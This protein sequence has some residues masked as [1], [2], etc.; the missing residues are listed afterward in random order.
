MREPGQGFVPFSPQA[1]I[2]FDVEIF[3]RESGELISRPGV[4]SGDSFGQ[5]CREL[6]LLALVREHFGIN[7]IISARLW[8]L[9]GSRAGFFIAGTDSVFD[10]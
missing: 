3:A 9:H 5:L 10:A 6:S 4:Y 2:D 1:L 7:S 8:D